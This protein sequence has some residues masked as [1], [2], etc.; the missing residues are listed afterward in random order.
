MRYR[1]LG[2]TD[3]KVSEIGFGTQTIGG[4]T[5]LGNREVGWGRTDDQISLMALRACLDHGINY[6]DTAE[7]YGW[8]HAEELIGKAFK[9]KRHLVVIATKAGYRVDKHKNVFVDYNSDYIERSVENSMKRLQTDYIDV[10]QLHSVP[11]DFKIPEQTIKTLDRLREAGKI[12]YYGVSVTKL[13]LGIGMVEAKKIYT[14]QVEYNLL[15]QEPIKVLSPKA[16]ENGVGIIAR[17]PL[18]T[19]FL[20]GKYTETGVSFPPNDIR[21]NMAQA[22][23]DEAIIKANKLSFLVNSNRTMSQSAIQ[24]LLADPAVSTVL[25][26]I[27]TPDQLAENVRACDSPRWQMKNCRW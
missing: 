13:G 11:D 10:F 21:S 16:L 24:F 22:K 1:D 12:R 5:I 8:G 20:T 2:R 15:Y 3:L 7:V 27:R 14:V 6:I 17:A 9:N 25:T 26:G 4:P 19:G 23:I 18:A